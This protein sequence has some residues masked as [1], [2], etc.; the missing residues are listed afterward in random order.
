M[1]I[2]LPDGRLMPTQTDVGWTTYARIVR[3]P[4][5]G[6]V[7]I[8]Y[9]E[10]RWGPLLQA[11]QRLPAMQSLNEQNRLYFA[12]PGGQWERI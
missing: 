5:V 8:G 11:V 3:K 7:F 1:S 6:W 12:E 4:G 9:S 10:P 2:R